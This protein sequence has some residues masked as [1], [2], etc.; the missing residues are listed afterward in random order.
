ML[1][2]LLL[3]EQKFGREQMLLNAAS[4]ISATTFPPTV[5]DLL[6]GNLRRAGASDLD[7]DTHQR[8]N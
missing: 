2:D 7:T 4:I 1:L 5:L 3:Q 8:T 6:L